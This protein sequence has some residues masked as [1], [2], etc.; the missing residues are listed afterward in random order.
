M[1]NHEIENNAAPAIQHPTLESYG[2]TVRQTL[3]TPTKPGKKPRPVWIVTG[4]VF[5]LGEL[6]RE[7]K[8]RKFRGEWSFFN[9][10]C[11]E[12]LAHLETNGRQ[13]FAEQVETSIERKLEKAARYQSYAANAEVRAERSAEKASTIGGMI[14]MGQPILVGHHSERRHRKDIQRIE[15]SMSDFLD[16]CQAIS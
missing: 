6:F 9:D 4:N 13:S 2:V 10:P 11:D 1:Q 16:L 3:T 8:G 15:H 5:G 12:I 7:A 14:P